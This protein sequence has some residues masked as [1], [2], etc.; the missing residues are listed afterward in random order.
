MTSL[1]K[2][3]VIT[4]FNFITGFQVVLINEKLIMLPQPSQGRRHHRDF[5]LE[6]AAEVVTLTM[7]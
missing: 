1:S 2:V 3:G 5:I 4:Y 7:E 6:A